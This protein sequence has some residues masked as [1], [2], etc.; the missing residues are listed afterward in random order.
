MGK[1]VSFTYISAWRPNF[2]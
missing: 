1:L 2:S